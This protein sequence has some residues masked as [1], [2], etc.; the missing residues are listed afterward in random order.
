MK[1]SLRR[2][3]AVMARRA[4]EPYHRLEAFAVV[5]LPDEK[6]PLELLQNII[7]RPGG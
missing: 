1:N 4:A 6:L 7:E 5:T 3:K 2:K